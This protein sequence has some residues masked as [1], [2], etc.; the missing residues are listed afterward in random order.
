MEAN[1]RKRNTRI[2]KDQSRL[3]A[4]SEYPSGRAVDEAGLG[5][6][7]SFLQEPFP[8]EPRLNRS[9]T[10]DN[11]PVLDVCPADLFEFILYFLP[12]AY[13]EKKSWTRPVVEVCGGVA[14]S[15][16]AA[17]AELTVSAPT[18]FNARFYIRGMQDGRGFEK[19]RA[20]VEHFLLEKLRQSA[21]QGSSL[22]R[23]DLSVVRNNYFKRQVCFL[24]S[25]L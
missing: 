16:V 17:D 3:D 18:D 14:Q 4:W 13:G 21:A 11:W 2:P 24:D 8:V 10:D 20:V 6:L 15:V 19:C 12:K 25:M 23:A 7:K 9:Q 5:V 1:A 22:S